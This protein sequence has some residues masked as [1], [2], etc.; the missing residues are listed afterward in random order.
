[1]DFHCSRY[2]SYTK[3]IK[4]VLRL[5][6]PKDPHETWLSRSI[7]L[8]DFPDRRVDS[9]GDSAR[10]HCCVLKQRR[11]DLD[12]F[13]RLFSLSGVSLNF[14]FSLFIFDKKHFFK[15]FLT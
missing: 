1:M 10:S 8:T 3:Y 12:Y 5:L 4:A 11:V 9:Q 2:G 13:S 14:D 6:T 7:N 15:R